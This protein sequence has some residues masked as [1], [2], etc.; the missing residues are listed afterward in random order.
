MC[1]KQGEDSRNALPPKHGALLKIQKYRNE[2]PQ[3]KKKK[4]KWISNARMEISMIPAEKETPG[5]FPSL[6]REA[7]EAALSCN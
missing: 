4:K 3:G 6:R 5:C 2:A 1:I 7:V